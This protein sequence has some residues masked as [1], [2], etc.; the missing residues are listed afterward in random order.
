[1]STPEERYIPH[2]STSYS[3]Y[4]FCELC[5]NLISGRYKRIK[6]CNHSIC[7]ECNI[8]PSCN[9]KIFCDCSKCIKL[10]N[11]IPK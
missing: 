9:T 11:K 8:C 10:I 2:P 6:C 4:E 5:N 7:I 1:M 3:I